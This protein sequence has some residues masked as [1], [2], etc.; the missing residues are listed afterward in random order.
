MTI[1]LNDV[2]AVLRLRIKEN[3]VAVDVSTA[4]TFEILLNPPKGLSRRKAATFTTDGTDGVIQ[5][6]LQ[7]GDANVVGEWS[8]QARVVLPSGFDLTSSPVS[9]TVERAG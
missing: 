7:A 1:R 8:V 9:L 2:G 6:T 3:G 5:Y 4:T